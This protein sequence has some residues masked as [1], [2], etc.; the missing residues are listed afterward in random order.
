MLVWVGK[1]CPR[2]AV[3]FSIDLWQI[4]KLL[5]DIFPSYI[6]FHCPRISHLL[7]RAADFILK[8][9]DE[10]D[11]KPQCLAPRWNLGQNKQT[12]CVAGSV[13]WAGWCPGPVLSFGGRWRGG[14]EGFL[15]W[16]QD[17]MCRIDLEKS[18]FH[19][20]RRLRCGLK[21][22]GAYLCNWWE[23]NPSGTHLRLSLVLSIWN[24]DNK[25]RS[26][27]L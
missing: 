5:L 4:H 19:Y 10:E 20:F 2:T 24:I 16:V 18:W 23:R 22:Y 3:W 8:T 25:W 17:E 15:G 14:Q 6:A 9:K 13:W 1:S 11:L 12:R 27:S 21:K 26:H 7:W